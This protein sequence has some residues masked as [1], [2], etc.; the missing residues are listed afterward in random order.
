MAK[1]LIQGVRV[2]PLK[3]IPNHIPHDWAR[4]DG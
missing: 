4:E 2:K 1:P 3:V